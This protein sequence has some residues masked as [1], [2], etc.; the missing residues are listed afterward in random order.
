MSGLEL[1]QTRG[2]NGVVF[3]PLTSAFSAARCDQ[4][5]FTCQCQ[6]K[7]KKASGFQI[8]HFYWS[9]SSDI[10]EVKRLITTNSTHRLSIVACQ[11]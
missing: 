2:L 1:G 6:S 7:D 11:A 5:P 9:V 4:S 8:S 10:M 3:A